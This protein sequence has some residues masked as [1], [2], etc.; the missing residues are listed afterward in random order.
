MNPAPPQFSNSSHLQLERVL[1]FCDAIFAIAVTL[2]VLEIKVPELHHASE[3]QLLQSLADLIPK[4]VGYVVS[5]LVVGSYWAK[6]HLLY[7]WVRHYDERMLWGNLR[8]LLCVAFIPFP[9]AFFSEYLAY[10][11]SLVLYAA[12]LAALGLAAWALCRQAINIPGLID[13]AVPPLQARWLCRSMLGAPVMCALAISLSFVSLTA[14]RIAMCLIPVMSALLA[15]RVRKAGIRTSFE[16]PH[17]P[18]LPGSPLNGPVSST[19]IQLP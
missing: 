3:M 5:F 18:S 19:V 13:P 1:L 8:M 6:H 4:I 2:L 11:T 9:T 14:A 17:Q 10:Q 15:R 12:S 16:R 7:S